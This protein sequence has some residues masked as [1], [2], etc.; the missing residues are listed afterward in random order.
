MEKVRRQHYVPRMYLKR[1]GYGNK[2]NEYITVFKLD[3]GTVMDNRKVEN[4]AVANYFYDTNKEQLMEILKEDLEIFP[5]L[6]DSEELLD[7][8]FTEHTLANEEAAISNMLNDLQENL[9]KICISRNRSLMIIFLHSLAYRT[10]QFRDQMDT[11]NDKTEEVLNSMCD[12]LGF[13]EDTKKKTVETNCSVGKNTQLYQILGIKPVLETMKMLLNNYDWYE[14]VNNT[15]LDFVVSDNPAHAVRVGFNDICI[16]ISCNKA[17]ILRIKDKTAPLIS[18][19]MPEN[20][21]INL[22]LNSVIAYNCMQLVTAQKFL[23]GTSDAINCMKS[24][25]EISRAIRNKKT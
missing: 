21:V 22:S 11:I 18:K 8:Q 7:E 14:A 9:S 4:F 2:D 5:E 1:F 23:F 6:C 20:G 16:P 19:D 17:V 12:N 15:E 25:W 10:K 13:D 3:D 24:L